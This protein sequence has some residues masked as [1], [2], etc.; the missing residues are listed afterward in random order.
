MSL[1]GPS[2][3]L[4]Q[5]T[6][7]LFVK[8]DTELLMAIWKDVCFLVL[9]GTCKIYTIFYF[10]YNN[11]DLQSLYDERSFSTIFCLKNF[12]QVSSQRFCSLPQNDI[13]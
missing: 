3:I 1:Y 10:N 6:G 8:Y 13:P 5:M 7:M 4:P 9:Y 12:I 2:R 11:K